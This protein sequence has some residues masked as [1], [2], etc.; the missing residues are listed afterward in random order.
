[1][2]GEKSLKDL[3]SAV[4]KIAENSPKIQKD[5]KD[6]RDVICG[7]N[8]I[9]ETLVSINQVAQQNK[10]GNLEKLTEKSRLKNI[11]H[12]KKL[13]KSTASIELLLKSILGKMDKVGSGRSGSGRLS[14]D[15]DDR[16]RLRRLGAISKSIE[17]IERLRGIDVKDFLFA[18]KKMKNI[19]KIMTNFLNLF[20]N[21]KN[22]K[23]MESTISLAN[24]S[25]DLIKKLSKIAI[26]AIPAKIGAKT[27]ERIF[28]GDG[29]KYKGILGI[30][31][32]LGQNQKTIIAGRLAA[33]HV[34]AAC[35]SL[36][37]SAMLLTG[38][39]VVG[40]PAMLGA[41][42]TKG[43]VWILTGTFKML[44]KASPKVLAGSVVLLIMSSSVITFALGL[45][46]MAKATK[47]FSWKQFGLMVASIGSIAGMLALI[48]LPVV[49]PFIAIGSG[50]L[51]LMSA[52]LGL[53][54]LSLMTWQNINVKKSMANIE[55]AIGG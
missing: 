17:I 44:T 31:R 50:A 53:F 10:K 48:G 46:L 20:R 19:H 41:L 49:A 21:F 23:E 24:S 55:T 12:K 54:A 27:I 40:I 11:D 37:L 25:V 45:G 6:I 13:L 22:T 42:F 7:T 43:I 28:L 47:N 34:K 16:D 8:G 9:L 38:I 3:T 35:T 52:S 5:V 30:L 1:M 14:R 33:K 18:K 39:A 15:T 51:L 2:A 29:K 26:L 36:F 4:Y 32:K